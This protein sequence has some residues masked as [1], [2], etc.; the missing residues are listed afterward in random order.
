MAAALLTLATSIL[1]LDGRSQ[2]VPGGTLAVVTLDFGDQS[3]V[4]RR[5]TCAAA[6][7]SARFPPDQLR[8][9]EGE[10]PA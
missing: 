8:L 4:C 3:L 7:P 1:A 5:E 9:L 6:A 10:L 2:R